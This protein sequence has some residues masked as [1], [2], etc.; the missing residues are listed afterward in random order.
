MDHGEGE[1]GLEQ[2]NGCNKSTGWCFVFPLFLFQAR[3]NLQPSLRHPVENTAQMTSNTTFTTWKAWSS[4]A[5]CFLPSQQQQCT[6]H[7]DSVAT[8]R[9]MATQWASTDDKNRARV[10]Q[11]YRQHALYDK[12]VL[13]TQQLAVGGCCFMDCTCTLQACPFLSF[14]KGMVLINKWWY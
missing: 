4:S 8:T 9:G 14:E 5:V 3:H 6:R 7:N 2:Q 10:G 11:G 12:T 1:F 13:K